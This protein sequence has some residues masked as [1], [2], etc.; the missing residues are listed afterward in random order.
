MRKNP[1]ATRV[2]RRAA[3]AMAAT[4]GG[5]RRS[6]RIAGRAVVQYLKEQGM[7]GKVTTEDE[8]KDI[9]AIG[10]AAGA[11]AGVQQRV[12]KNRKS[13]GKKV[14]GPVARRKAIKDAATKGAENQSKVS[15]YRKGGDDNPYM[16]YES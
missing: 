6:G 8:F 9:K 10:T 14:G 11:E 3:K 5:T 12:I 16:N 15:F 4:A 2:A 1:K 7:T 13:F